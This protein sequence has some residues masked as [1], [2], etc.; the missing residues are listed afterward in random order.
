MYKTD[1]FNEHCIQQI[2]TALQGIAFRVDG[3]NV[4]YT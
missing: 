4:I 1:S 2:L 3:I